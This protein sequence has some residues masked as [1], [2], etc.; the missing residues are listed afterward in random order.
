MYRLLGVGSSAGALYSGTEAAPQAYRE[1]RL[2][3]KVRARGGAVVDD[4]D[5]QIPSYLARHNVPPIRNWPAPRM[6]WEAVAE[7]VAP[8][9]LAGETPLLIGGDCS[10]VVGAA[11][12]LAEVYGE[13]A[14]IIAMDGHIDAMAPHADR[15]VGAAA[16]GLWLAT[17][18]SL[19]W[20]G[21]LLEPQRVT[22]VGYSNDTPV[23]VEG[24]NTLS[25]A[26]ARGMGVQAAARQVLS[27][28][29][30]D[31]AILLHFDVDVLRQDEMPAAYS[32]N[33]N[34][35]SMDEAQALLNIFLSDTRVGLLEVTEYSA[36]RDL[37]L[38][39]AHK[40]TGMLATALAH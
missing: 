18:P 40:L 8:L 27:S 14:H 20:Q 15:S 3:E 6:V 5:I 13:R 26:Q 22:V 11:Q 31:A 9:L 33:A 4:G 12:A 35:M 19:F 7:R 38:A 10:I 21:P 23:D 28:I 29:E 32:P 30:P 2:V 24:I 1:A 17:Q 25:A 37:D 16:L 36:L 39:C 34:G